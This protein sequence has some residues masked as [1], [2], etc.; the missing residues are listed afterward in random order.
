M[1]NLQPVLD[2]PIFICS[3]YIRN[4]LVNDSISFVLVISSTIRH[5]FFLDRVLHDAIPYFYFTSRYH[6]PTLFPYSIFLYLAFIGSNNHPHL[7]SN[8]LLF[9]FYGR[10]NRNVD[11][12]TPIFIDLWKKR[13]PID[14]TSLFY[15]KRN[16][17]YYYVWSDANISISNKIQKPK[18]KVIKINNIARLKFI[19]K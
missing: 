7:W 12:S 9:R 8:M 2:F 13:N 19:R 6:I 5:I 10:F 4:V 18:T 17:I 16:Y 15:Q 3:T 1:E 11:K 14:L